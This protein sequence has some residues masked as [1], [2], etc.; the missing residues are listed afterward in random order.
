[1]QETPHLDRHF[2]REGVDFKLAI[3]LTSRNAHG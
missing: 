3:L 2:T 1:M